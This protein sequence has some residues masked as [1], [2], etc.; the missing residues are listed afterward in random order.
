[1]KFTNNIDYDNPI[2]GTLFS[3]VQKDGK[4]YPIY[5]ENSNSSS[6]SSSVLTLDITIPT[7]GWNDCHVGDYLKYVEIADETITE[8][9]TPQLIFSAENG[10]AAQTC[11]IGDACETLDGKL[12]VYAVAVPTA[13]IPAKLCLFGA[14]SGASSHFPIASTT[15]AGIVKIGENIDVTADGTIS[16]PGLSDLDGN[17]VPDAVDGVLATDEDVEDILNEVYG[18]ETP[19]D[20]EI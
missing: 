16:V 2:K 9:M 17:G 4:R 5:F 19:V 18:D 15:R 10:K 20:D 13:A 11:G 14:A 8:E 7:T 12:R 6:T 1:M 3:P